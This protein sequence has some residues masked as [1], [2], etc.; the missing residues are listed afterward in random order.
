M[1]C[2]PCRPADAM[3]PYLYTHLI[4]Y[5]GSDKLVSFPAVG[6]ARD[7]VDMKYKILITQLKLC[8]YA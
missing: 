8:T 4:L 5:K 3:Q 6:N 1:P 7:N 2:R